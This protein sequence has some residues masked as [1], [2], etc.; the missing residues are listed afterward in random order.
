MS[1]IC[2][3]G[4]EPRLEDLL[5]DSILADLLRADRIAESE[6]RSLI[7]EARRSFF[8]DGEPLSRCD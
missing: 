7:A 1:H 3:S 6:L 8:A 5:A 4:L 2:Q